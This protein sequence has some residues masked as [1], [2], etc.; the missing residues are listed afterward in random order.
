[1]NGANLSQ[2]ACV[3]VKMK[4]RQPKKVCTVLSGC[5]QW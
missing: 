4:T 1:M 2:G 5:G 3:C